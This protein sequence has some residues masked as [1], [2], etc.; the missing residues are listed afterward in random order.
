[1]QHRGLSCLLAFLT[2][3]SPLKSPAQGS[4]PPPVADAGHALSVAA[5]LRPGLPE[6]L[7][8]LRTTARLLHTTAHPD[9]EDGGMLAL[10]SHGRGASVMLLTLTRGE[11]GQNK[12]GS[13]LFDELGVLRTLELLASDRY[14][15]AQQRF[16]RAA[17]FG[18]SKDPQES[19]AKWRGHD[20]PL[21]DMVRVIRTFRPDVMVS[22]FQGSSRDGHGHHQAA[23]ILTP[24]AFRAAADSRRFPQQIRDGLLPWQVK[25]LYTDNVREG[26]DYNVRLDTGVIDPALHMSYAQFAMEGLHH[27]LSQGAGSY[28]LQAGPHYSRY[29]LIQSAIAFAPREGNAAASAAPVHE[30]DFFDGIDTSLP[31]LASRLGPEQSNLPMLRGELEQAQAEVAKA[32]AAA[33]KDPE[34]AAPFL[35]RGL[36]LVRQMDGQVRAARISTVSRNDLLLNL[37]TKAGQFEDAIAAALNVDLEITAEKAPAPDASG[38]RSP[39]DVSSLGVAFP[40]ENLLV[41]ETLHNRGSHAIT[42]QRMKL[43]VPAGWNVAVIRQGLGKSPP[44]GTAVCQFRVSVPPGS[45]YTA[46]HWRRHDPEADTVYSVDPVVVRELTGRDPAGNSEEL[47]QPLRARA[48][49]HDHC[50]VSGA[51]AVADASDVVDPIVSRDA[52]AYAPLPFLPFPVTGQADYALDNAPATDE[53]SRIA[54]TAMMAGANSS[55]LVPLAIAP[56]FSVLL[57]PATQVAPIGARSPVEVS[58]VVKN[59]LVRGDVAAVNPEDDAGV[60]TLDVPAGWRVEPSQVEVP[61]T[62]RSQEQAFKFKVL[63]GDLR[64]GRYQISASLAYMGKKYAQ[65][66]STVSREDIGGF[67]YYQPAVQRVTAVPVR[68]PVKPLNI[69]YIMGAGDDI[70]AV[71]KQIGLPVAM[72]TP[73]DLAGGNLSRF[74][75]IVLGIRAYDTRKDVRDLN[76]RLLQYVFDGG[77]L[78]VQYNA[79]VADFNSGKFTPYPAQISRDRVSV[80]EAPVEILLPG[81]KIF[82]QPNPITPGDFDGW[83]QERGLNFMNQWDPRF[84][85][86]LASHDPGEAPQ[87]G[88]M[89]RARYGKGVYIFTGYSFFRE[90]P[91]GVG[92]AIRLFVNL[93]NAGR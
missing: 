40:G 25:K 65:G 46:Q 19:F 5:P 61:V 52:S 59:N 90:L 2:A 24:E 7:L 23:G 57:D 27:Q 67:Y 84:E 53:S 74:D 29:K 16:T 21:E 64:E 68:L 83:V 30:N 47:R 31:G 15:G 45:A 35:M 54:A 32:T 48:A 70:P 88:G 10:E 41:T 69:G 66:Y 62:A 75:T 14:Y 71:L 63:P 81:D 4:P 22:R 42:A 86:L 37:A 85:P 43:A 79:G 34:A 6:L 49:E 12:V 82:A 9:D 77:A 3:A 87:K 92:G 17:D 20:L 11:G 55:A 8:R 58:V 26:E 50:V 38:S 28:S 13:N 33:A 1:M 78:V 18:F 51:P 73:H 80:E 91:A 44:Q 39:G 76:P 60:L 93:L 72:I 56:E 89:M 36:A